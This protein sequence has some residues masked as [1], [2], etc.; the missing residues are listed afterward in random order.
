MARF[1][2]LSVFATLFI[3]KNVGKMTC[4]YYKTTY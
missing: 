2:F 1:A 4:T 3:L